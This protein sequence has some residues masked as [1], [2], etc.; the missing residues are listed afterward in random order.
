HHGPGPLAGSG[1]RG[2]GGRERR[3]LGPALGPQ[4]RR[5][6]GLLCQP[7]APARSARAVA[8]HPPQAGR[9]APGALSLK[10]DPAFLFRAT[11]GAS[12]FP[13]LLRQGLPLAQRLLETSDEPIERVAVRCGFSSAATLRL[14]FRRFV[15]LSPMSYRSIF[16]S[17]SA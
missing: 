16:Q 11:R 10:R 1:D 4:L 2:G 14:H 7:S 6:A 5:R 12:P 9:G 15:G 17:A 13:R 3:D 8:A